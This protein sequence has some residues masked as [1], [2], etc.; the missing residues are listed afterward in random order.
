M[1]DHSFSRPDPRPRPPGHSLFKDAS[2]DQYNTLSS[3]HIKVPTSDLLGAFTRLT[4]QN[5]EL[6]ARVAHVERVRHE[7]RQRWDYEILRLRT[8]LQE[9]GLPWDLT[10][11]LTL[12][13]IQES[14]EKRRESEQHALE[15]ANRQTEQLK[16]KLKAVGA[17]LE[18][19]QKNWDH[20]KKAFREKNSELVA[21]IR[22]LKDEIARNNQQRI[23]EKEEWNLECRRLDDLVSESETRRER[24]ECAWKEAV[25]ILDEMVYRE[26][27][28]KEYLASTL[29]VIRLGICDDEEQEEKRLAFLKMQ[30]QPEDSKLE[31]WRARMQLGQKSSVPSL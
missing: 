12:N 26:R 6:K 21:E 1:S 24:E 9:N 30:A 23:I 27:V 2:H 3:D 17:K 7:E 4:E 15:Q 31:H 5:A 25:E 20:A 19:K 18:G 14:E 22:D 11:P 29:R 8:I 13:S 10:R 16:R 28:E